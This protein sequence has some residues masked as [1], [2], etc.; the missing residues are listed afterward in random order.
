MPL[1]NGHAE[2]RFDGEHMHFKMEDTGSVVSCAVTAEYLASRGQLDGIHSQSYRALFTLYRSDIERIA[3]A[4][5]DM[6]SDRPIVT[7]FDLH[8]KFPRF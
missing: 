8:I 4:K 6:G 7:A 3:S 1:T 2:F 5:Y